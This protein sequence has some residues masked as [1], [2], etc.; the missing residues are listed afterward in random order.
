MAVESGSVQL[1]NAC[2]AA[3]WFDLPLFFKEADR[4]LCSSGVIA[5][6]S[7]FVPTL[8]HPT[9]STQLGKVLYDFYSDKLGSFW[10]PGA[11]HLE[12]EYANITLPYANTLREEVWTDETSHSLT[13]FVSS[14]KT[15]S[16]YQN[17]CKSLGD[18]AGL[19]LLNEFTSK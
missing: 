13:D 9:R 18:D 10:G 19:E 14:M 12:T 1:V 17:Y 3:H 11:K 6:A 15:W 4:V 2:V 7:Y 5:L 16:A 8:I